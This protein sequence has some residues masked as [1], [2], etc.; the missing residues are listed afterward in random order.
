MVPRIAC[1]AN[2]RQF[3]SNQRDLRPVDEPGRGGER[4]VHLRETFTGCGIGAQR[5]LFNRGEGDRI[6]PRSLDDGV[7][8]MRRVRIE[9]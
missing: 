4:G 6:V 7:A 3:R 8:L 5:L 2:L 9:S 1:R